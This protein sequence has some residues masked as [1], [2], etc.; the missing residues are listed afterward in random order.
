MFLLLERYYAECF[1][2]VAKT[3]AEFAFA[4]VTHKSLCCDLLLGARRRFGA[5]QSRNPISK[6]KI[7][8]SR[9]G[10]FILERITG[11]E[12]A[13]STLARWRSTK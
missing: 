9:I 10:I 2:S 8:T 3:L 11:L 13:T 12:P 5:A 7:P 6:T 1:C 4:N